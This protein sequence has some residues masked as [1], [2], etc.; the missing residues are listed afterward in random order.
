MHNSRVESTT[1]TTDHNND[2]GLLSHTG[3][4]TK[5]PFLAVVR[6]FVLLK[7]AGTVDRSF[8]PRELVD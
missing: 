8:V 6:V 5:P 4:H 7:T 1:T 3:E 2:H